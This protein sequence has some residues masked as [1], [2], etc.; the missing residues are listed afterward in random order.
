LIELSEL[1]CNKKSLLNMRL[2][3]FAAVITMAYGH[4]ACPALWTH[5]QGYCFRLFVDRLR[6]LD[7]AT[8]CGQFAPCSGEGLGQLAKITDAQTNQFVRLYASTFGDTNP[9]GFDVWTGASDNGMEGRWMWQD[10]EPVTNTYWLQGQPD[11]GRAQGGQNVENC[12]V[13]NSVSGQWSDTFCGA[14]QPYICMMKGEIE[15]TPWIPGRGFPGMYPTNPNNPN[16]PQVPG[17]PGVGNPGVNPNNPNQPGFPRQP[18][19]QPI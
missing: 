4:S 11:N 5:F 1:S 2:L 17:Q 7:A 19:G 6:F 12:A 3:I 8:T 14:M 15:R 18:G 13:L 9:A 10:G 16:I